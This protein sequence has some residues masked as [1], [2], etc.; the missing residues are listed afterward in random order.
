M[1]LGAAALRNLE[2]LNNQVTAAGRVSCSS[3]E[4]R[5][6][7]KPREADACTGSWSID[8]KCGAER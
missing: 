4:E 3:A 1:N 2:I 5:C 6:P 8:G 7:F